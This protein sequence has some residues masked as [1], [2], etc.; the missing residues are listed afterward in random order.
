MTNYNKYLFKLGLFLTLVGVVV[1]LSACN[2]GFGTFGSTLPN[3][4]VYE[5]DDQQNSWVDKNGNA[6]QCT[7]VD[8]VNIFAYMPGQGCNYLAEFHKIDDTTE[9]SEVPIETGGGVAKTYCI[10]TRYIEV[11]STGKKLLFGGG[12]AFCLKQTGNSHNFTTCKGLLRRGPNSKSQTSDDDD[13]KKEDDE[14]DDNNN[15]DND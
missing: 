4:R 14:E 8:N 7:V 11:D 5:Y 6:V 13:D 12:A 2:M 3:C 15:N 1:C 10:K 9:I